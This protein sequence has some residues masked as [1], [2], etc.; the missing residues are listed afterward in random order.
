MLYAHSDVADTWNYDVPTSQA[1]AGSGCEQSDVYTLC[2]LFY[3]L[4]CLYTLML[5]AHSDVADTWN[6]DDD[7]DV[8]VW[9][10]QLDCVAD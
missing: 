6:Y 3:T 1:A 2:C 4:C 8:Y 10:T 5:Y 9:W 7:P